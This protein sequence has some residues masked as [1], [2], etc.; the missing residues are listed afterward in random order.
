[1]S[2]VDIK[3]PPEFDTLEVL[4]A[5]VAIFDYNKGYLKTSEHIVGEDG[6][7]GIRW[8]NREILRSQ[9]M[10]DYYSGGK[11]PPIIKVYDRDRKSTRLNSSHTDIS[12]M[13]SSA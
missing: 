8:A 3:A 5:A 11:K 9:F 4:A 7:D 10:V 1:M 13:P 2:V 6:R 12:R